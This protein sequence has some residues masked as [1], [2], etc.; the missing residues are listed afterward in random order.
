MAYSLPVILPEGKE[1]DDLA[2]YFWS[3]VD[4]SG[5]CWLWTGVIK[6]GGYGLVFFHKRK[7]L[8]HRLSYRLVW[9]PFKGS[10]FV[11]HRCD[12]PPCVNPAHLFLGTHEDNIE[13]MFAKGRHKPGRNPHPELASAGERNLVC[14]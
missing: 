1:A 12:N 5:D 4:N 3:R 10:L 2:A 13:D 9:G 7:Y 14:R 11:L 8:A 6:D